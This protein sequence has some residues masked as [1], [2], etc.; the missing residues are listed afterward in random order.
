M[1]VI[2]VENRE[3]LRIITIDNVKKRNALN[4]EGYLALTKALRDADEDE[5][6]SVV[7]LTG[8]GNFYSSG[9][10]II[11][12]MSSTDPPEYVMSVLRDLI[13]AF[14]RCRKILVAVVNGPSIGIAATTAILCDVIYAEKDAYFYTP[15]TALGLC[16]EG[17]SSLTFPQIMGKTKASEMLLLNHKMTAEEALRFNVVSEVYTRDEAQTKIWPRIEAF[18]K[19]PHKSLIITKGLIQKFDIDALE[20]ANNAEVEALRER[21]SSEDC[22]QAAMEFAQ[23]KLKKSSL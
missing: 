6:V 8:A 2:K 21:T 16:C 23:R 10:D 13:R 1:S 14:Y 9:N 5:S 17:C 15:F 18:A 20:A 11:S 3:R 19:L 22:I 12:A 4:R 7:A